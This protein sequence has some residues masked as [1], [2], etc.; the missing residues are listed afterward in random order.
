M[1]DPTTTDSSISSASSEILIRDFE[2]EQ[3]IDPEKVSEEEFLAILAEQIAYMI[4]HRL[5]HLFS[6][7]YRM[8]VREDL[9]SAA[10]APEAPEPANI[11]IARLVLNRQKQRNLTKATIK[12][13]ELGEEWDW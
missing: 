5:E 10:L 9:V 8:D 7:L 3:T 11:G 1:A 6:L 4:E 13:E 2:I 12:P